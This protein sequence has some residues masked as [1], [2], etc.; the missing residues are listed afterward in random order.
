MNGSVSAD[1][2]DI[3]DLKKR[4]DSTEIAIGLI[5]AELTK[6]ID[7]KKAVEDAHLKA[8][9]SIYPTQVIQIIDKIK[10]AMNQSINL[11]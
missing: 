8:Q 6:Q 10:I 4:L 9:T 5:L 3:Y 2:D 7:S 11:F 1:K